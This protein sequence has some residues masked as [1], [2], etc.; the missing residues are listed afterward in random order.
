VLPTL[1]HVVHAERGSSAPTSWGQGATACLRP[2]QINPHRW[3]IQQR[4]REPQPWSLL[5]HPDTFCSPGM[6]KTIP[7]L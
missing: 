4:P 1:P 2:T 7:Q 5:P 3:L 6:S